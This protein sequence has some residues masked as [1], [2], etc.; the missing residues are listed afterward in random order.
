[1][2]GLFRIIVTADERRWPKLQSLLDSDWC[3]LN[4]CSNPGVDYVLTD[5]DDVLYLSTKLKNPDFGELK[6]IAAKLN[7][8]LI[9]PAAPNRLIVISKSIPLHEVLRAKGMNR[10]VSARLNGDWVRMDFAKKTYDHAGKRDFAEAAQKVDLVILNIDYSTAPQDME[11]GLKRDVCKTGVTITVMD[12]LRAKPLLW[13]AGVELTD[14]SEEKRG[15]IRAWAS[16]KGWKTFEPES[17]ANVYKTFQEPR[18]SKPGGDAQHSSRPEPVPNADQQENM[19][20][21]ERM[22]LDVMARQMKRPR[23]LNKVDL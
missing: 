1:M 12:N 20:E 23:D 7:P 10:A 4:L 6:S 8:R 22:A 21:I 18:R 11:Q 13:A 19:D 14:A 3:K 16:Q 2:A 9:I 15:L 5:T 17:M